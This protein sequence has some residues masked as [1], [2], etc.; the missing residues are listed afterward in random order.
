MIYFFHRAGDTRS[1]ETRI[2]P[3]GR[4]YELVVTEGR[5]SHIERFADSQ[6]LERRQSELRY[7][8]V[9]HGWRDVG[10]GDDSDDE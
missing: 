8:W 7:S 4:G 5:Q 6:A 2:E 10:P 1:C 3:S 9:A